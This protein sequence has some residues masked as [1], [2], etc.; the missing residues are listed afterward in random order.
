MLVSSPG[1]R[2]WFGV[3]LKTFEISIEEH[4]GKVHGK[5]CERGPKFSSWIRF[6]GKGLSLLLKGVESCYGLKERAPFRKFWSEGNRAYSLELRRNNAGR[7]LFC[8][9]RDAENKRFSL[10]FPEGRG[11]VGGWKVLASKLRSLGVSPLQWNGA[12]MENHTPAQ[13]PSSSIIRDSCSLRDCPAPRDA[14]W[15]EAEKEALVRN[16]ELL[17]GAL[18]AFG[19]ET[20]TTSLTLL[21]S[22]RG[23]KAPG[24]RRFRGR[25]FCLKKWKPSVGC[26]DGDKG[27][28]CLVWVG[29]LG[30]PLHLWGRSLF[31]KFGDSCE[32]FVAVDENKVERRNLKWARILVE[33]KGWEHPSSLQVVA[34][35]FCFALQL[36]WENEVCISTVLPSHGAGAWKLEEDEVASSPAKG[37]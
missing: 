21:P 2:C 29:I 3:E 25:S 37:A 11:L 18:W 8:V 34:S 28:P 22:G 24:A 23:Q 12:L 32:R 4:K 16:E 13:A 31:R 1:G 33:I 15:I 30:L 6:G 17:A 14:V 36:W 27:D 9:V 35:P 10:A 7:F 5:I 20:L 26:F 19:R